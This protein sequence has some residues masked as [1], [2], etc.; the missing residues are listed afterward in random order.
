MLKRLRRR[1]KPPSLLL[2][3]VECYSDG[4]TFRADLRLSAGRI[5]E[6]GS[7]LSA[8]PGEQMLELDGHLAYPGLINAHDH[9]ELDFLPR[10][11]TP[12][13]PSFYDWAED[14]YRPDEAPIRDLR[15][16][17]LPDR[18]LWGA[19]KNII[20]G[21]TTVMHHDA[22]HSAVFGDG[23]PVHVV[24]PYRW[25]HSLGFG[26]NPRDAYAGGTGPFVI[27]AAEGADAR[28]RNEI[29]QLDKLGVLGDDTILVHGV[30]ITVAQW[31]RL[32]ERGVGL[33]WCPS[34]NLYLFGQTVEIGA[35][36][37]EV[38]VALGTDSTISG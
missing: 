8:R 15:R 11:G 2:R 5:A 30:A 6:I 17:G 36:P 13:Y 34:S 10:L 18:L 29:E 7:G 3:Q 28:A 21:V 37:S 22:Y 19:L 12:P 35:L 26:A 27:H 25:A 23:F 24:H 31:R 9:L 38:S 33:V 16:I 20:S 4:Q 14:V 1:R 32:S